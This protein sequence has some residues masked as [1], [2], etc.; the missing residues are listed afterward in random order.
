MFNSS[1]VGSL[2]GQVIRAC[3]RRNGITVASSRIIVP[4][5]P[6]QRDLESMSIPKHLA[7]VSDTSI[8][9][10]SGMIG[11]SCCPMRMVPLGR[12]TAVTPLAR[13]YDLVNVG[14]HPFTKTCC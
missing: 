5:P 10:E 14:G 12:S 1:G 7:W 13:K 9:S 6:K 2:I 4:H 11:T 3:S 8:I